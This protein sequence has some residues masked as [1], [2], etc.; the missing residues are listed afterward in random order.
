VF[1]LLQALDLLQTSKQ[2]T[3]YLKREIRDKMTEMLGVFLT[4]LLPMISPPIHLFIVEITGNTSTTM[5]YTN[6]EEAKVQ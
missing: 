6:Y 2:K 1:I 4:L 3:G 5:Q